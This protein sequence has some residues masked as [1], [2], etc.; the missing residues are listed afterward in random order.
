MTA[1]R[2]EILV[3]GWPGGNHDALSQGHRQDVDPDAHATDVGLYRLHD[4]PRPG[5]Q[6]DEGLPPAVDPHRFDVLRLRTLKER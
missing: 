2:Q 1:G 6:L 4:E 5:Q 3:G